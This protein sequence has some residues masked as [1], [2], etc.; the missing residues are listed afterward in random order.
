MTKIP[1]T[2]DKMAKMAKTTTTEI[3]IADQIEDLTTKTTNKAAD[4]RQ[5][6]ATAEAAEE[7]RYP[8]M[9]RLR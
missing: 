3:K 5:S 4:A 9:S 1:A 7:N 2:T 8:P 6:E